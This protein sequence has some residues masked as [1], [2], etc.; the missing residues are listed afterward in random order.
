MLFPLLFLRAVSFRALPPPPNHLSLLQL[1][2]IDSIPFDVRSLKF[3]VDLFLLLLL[4]GPAWMAL[5]LEGA[6]GNSGTPS[7]PIPSASTDSKIGPLW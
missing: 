6:G 7:N 2:A 3:E 4:P 1:A 5:P